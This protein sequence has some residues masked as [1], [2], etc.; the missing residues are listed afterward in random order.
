MGAR[1][2]MVVVDLCCGDGL[3]TAPLA[4]IVDRVYAIDIDAAMLDCARA[5]FAAAGATNC[6]LVLADAMTFDAIV[7]EPVDYVFL[8]NTFH[9]VPDQLGLARAVAAILKPKGQFGV[10]NWH[11]LPREETMVLGKPRGPRTEVRME[12]D[13]VAVIIEPAGLSLNRTVEFPP[14][15]YGVI[16]AKERE[17]GDGLHNRE[18]FR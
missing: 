6:H 1:P 15:H 17:M 7:P 2:G 10:V 9:G 11:G 3:F 5:L 18:A 4:H 13:D 12:A 8:A 16:F 14:Y